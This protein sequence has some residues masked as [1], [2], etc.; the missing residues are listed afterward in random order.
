MEVKNFFVTTETE[1]TTC[2]QVVYCS[3]SIRLPQYP[4]L[5]NQKKKRKFITKKKWKDKD[6]N[7][8]KENGEQKNREVS[9][10]ERQFLE[11][12]NKIDKP[13]ARLIKK[14]QEKTQIINIKNERSDI[15]TIL[16]I[17]K[18]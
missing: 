11:K 15:T 2:Q 3:Y 12:I 6:Q 18:G 7:R 10:M 1:N 5:R 4:L 16:Q 9:A 17:L 13:L 14:R 8:N